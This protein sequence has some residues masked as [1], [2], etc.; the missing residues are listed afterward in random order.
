MHSAEDRLQLP[1]LCNTNT[2][3]EAGIRHG[4]ILLWQM[5]CSVSVRTPPRKKSGYVYTATSPLVIAVK[6]GCWRGSVD[7]LRARY[8]T[9]YGP[10][11]QLKVVYVDD[12]V[13]G[14]AWM[15]QQFNEYNCG[16]EMFDKAYLTKY[17]AALKS[18]RE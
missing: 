7:D 10:D 13:A 5:R 4:D 11:V 17:P 8:A 14:E 12:K 2:P 9:P 18:L 3:R 15:H 16:G 6:I 1:C